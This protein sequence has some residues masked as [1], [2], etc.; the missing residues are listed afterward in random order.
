MN[1]TCVKCG[2][3][4]LMRVNLSAKSGFSTS[5]EDCYRK[6]RAEKYARERDA[7]RLSQ[8]AYYEANKEQFFA[9]NKKVRALAAAKQNAEKAAYRESAAFAAEV[10]RK[11]Q[12]ARDRATEWF[13]LNHVKAR[14]YVRVRRAKQRGKFNARSRAYEQQKRNAVPKWA[15]LGTIRL[16]YEAAAAVSRAT[17]QTWHVDHI[18]PLQHPVVCGLHC[19]ANLQ[20]LPAT[21]N[22]SKGNRHWPDMPDL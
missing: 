15:N 8:R 11:K 5:C 21:K 17:G 20:L 4:K 6:Q 7:V 2:V 22:L 13:R 14:N 9:R 16:L 10:E 1:S 12:T 19:P 18:V 3:F